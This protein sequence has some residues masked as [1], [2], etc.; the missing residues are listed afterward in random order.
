M[1]DQLSS[2]FKKKF[3]RFRNLKDFEIIQK[4]QFDFMKLFY[5]IKKDFELS[6]NNII[7]FNDEMIEFYHQIKNEILFKDIHIYSF[8]NHKKIKY[9]YL[10][11]NLYYQEIDEN[12][13]EI[14]LI[15]EN[16][17]I[18]EKKILNHDELRNLLKELNKKNF[19]KYSEN[20]RK[21]MKIS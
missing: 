20:K 21:E 13:F 14:F 3:K 19:L 4:I 16:H 7:Q 5:E 10:R 15:N 18:N 2:Y 1:K 12:L 8:I 6:D 11:L 9:D 17:R